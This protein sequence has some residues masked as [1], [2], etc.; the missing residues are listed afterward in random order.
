VGVEQIIARAVAA[1]VTEIAEN[2]A[3]CNPTVT[4]VSS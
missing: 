4:L 1:W 3:S 2:T